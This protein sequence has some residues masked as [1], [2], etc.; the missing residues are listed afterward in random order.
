MTTAESIIEAFDEIL[1]Y[2]YGR[3]RGRDYAA[4]DDLQYAKD[5]VERG[6]TVPIASAIFYHRM[7]IM[8]ERWCRNRDPNSHENWPAVLK[9]FDDNILSALN[10]VAAGGEPIAVWE[11]SESQWRARIRLFFNK[12]PKRCWNHDLWGAA[13]DEPNCR[14]PT[15]LIEEAKK[16]DNRFK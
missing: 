10:R 13:P 11:Q 16:K 3:S 14:A 8:H 5:W 4:K 7:S 1:D 9:V 12:L 6:L 2:V 15:R